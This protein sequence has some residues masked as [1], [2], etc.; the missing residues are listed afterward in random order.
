MDHYFRI[1]QQVYL[2]CS[3]NRLRFQCAVMTVVTG[4]TLCTQTHTPLVLSTSS[5]A[6]AII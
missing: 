1:Q 5:N 2:S 4:V 6:F 3:E